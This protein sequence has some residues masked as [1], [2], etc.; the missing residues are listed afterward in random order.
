[1]TKSLSDYILSPL[2]MFYYYYDEDFKVGNS[3]NLALFIINEMIS[4]VIVLC[5]CIYNEIL[6]LFCCNLEYNTH[7]QVSIRAINIENEE[8]ESSEDD[9][10]DNNNNK[11]MM[12]INNI[13]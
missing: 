11:K 4:I 9:D 2:L 3:Q 10:E 1:M 6:I 12:M 5:G 13:L 8:E 7:H